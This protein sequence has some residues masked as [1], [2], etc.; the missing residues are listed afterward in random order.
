MAA[1]NV[2]EQ[3]AEWRRTGNY[4]MLTG[5]LQAATVEVFKKLGTTV[6]VEVRR[7]P[8]GTGILLRVVQRTRLAVWTNVLA[9]V[10]SAKE[11]EDFTRLVGLF[12]VDEI[13][14]AEY[15]VFSVRRG[16][17]EWQVLAVKIKDLAE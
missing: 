4:A 8:L 5:T 14:P 2:D 16:Q 3:I 15:S 17:S 12:I 13:A 10:L 11:L 9:G 6:D 1:F 7:F